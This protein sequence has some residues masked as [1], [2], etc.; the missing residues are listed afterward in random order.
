M[1]TPAAFTRRRFLAS[2][3]AAGALAAYG[4]PFTASRAGA[5]TEGKL[6]AAHWGV[7][8]AKVE[9]GRFVSAT[10]FERDPFPATAMV[11]STPSLVHSKSRIRYPM[12]RR[13]FLE[14][15]P[16][17][18]RTERGNGDFVRVSWDEALDL[19]ARE[20][21]RVKEAFGPWPAR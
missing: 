17:G 18:D 4:L 11:E 1:T 10:P 14:N 7:M 15:G 3:A 21:T 19:V 2:S 8:R 16:E 13:G 6:T 9:N 12:V 20:L 5:S